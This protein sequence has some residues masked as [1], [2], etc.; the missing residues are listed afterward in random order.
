[1]PGTA[2]ARQLKGGKGPLLLTATGALDPRTLAELKRVLKPGP[3]VYVLG[4]TQAISAHTFNQIAEAGFRP[5]RIGG[6]DRFETAVDVAKTI[7]PDVHARPGDHPR[8][9]PG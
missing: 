3:F 7:V 2:L 5:T 9:R 4:Q 8:P 1:M 6:Q